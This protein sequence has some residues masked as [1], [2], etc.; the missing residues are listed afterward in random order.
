VVEHDVDA[1]LDR[2]IGAVVLGI[3]AFGGGV[4]AGENDL[5][6]LAHLKITTMTWTRQMTTDLVF[7]GEL[8]NNAIDLLYWISVGG[9]LIIWNRK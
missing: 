9:E 2:L 8:E 5:T 1:A 6:L 4:R 3:L 7:A